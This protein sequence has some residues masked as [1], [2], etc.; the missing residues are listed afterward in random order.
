MQNCLDPLCFS[1]VYT[2][3]TSLITAPVHIQPEDTEADLDSR[4]QNPYTWGLFA[5]EDG[6]PVR[7]HDLPPWLAIRAPCSDLEGQFQPFHEDGP[8]ERSL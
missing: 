5:G 3:N 6:T 4:I 8:S 1:I 2:V 7:W